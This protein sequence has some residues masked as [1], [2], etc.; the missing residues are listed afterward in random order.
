MSELNLGDRFGDFIVVGDY[1]APDIDQRSQMTAEQRQ[2]EIMAELEALKAERDPGMSGALVNNPDTFQ[3]TR[4]EIIA[5]W[6]AL[7]GFRR[8]SAREFGQA[9][10]GEP[11]QLIFRHQQVK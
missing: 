11:N 8:V 10:R 2:H 9:V 5:N 4:V 1:K 6:R 7:E 3:R